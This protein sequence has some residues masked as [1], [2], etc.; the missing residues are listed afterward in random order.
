M[1]SLRSRLLALWLMLAVSGVV[2]GLLLVEFI[3]NLR[4]RRL[5]APKRPSLDAVAN[6][7]T[8]ISSS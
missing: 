1:N 2:I 4:M 7:P 6:S 8:G 3:G 5:G